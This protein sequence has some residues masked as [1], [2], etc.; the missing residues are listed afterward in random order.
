MIRLTS[1]VLCCMGLMIVLGCHVQQGAPEKYS[2]Y[3]G[4]KVKTTVNIILQKPCFSTRTY[5]LSEERLRRWQERLTIPAGSVLEI[6][7]VSY[8]RTKPGIVHYF[9]CRWHRRGYHIDFDYDV[10]QRVNNTPVVAPH[11]EVLD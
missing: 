8:R 5:G 6:T 2:R 11:F 7:G 3:I 4:K 9:E 1:A 10:I